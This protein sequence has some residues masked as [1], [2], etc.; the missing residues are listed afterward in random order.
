[1]LS[2]INWEIRDTTVA[3]KVKR[4][5]FQRVKR[6]PCPSPKYATDHNTVFIKKLSHNTKWSFFHRWLLTL[7]H[8][9]LWV[10]MKLSH[11]HIIS[12]KEKNLE[13]RF[14]CDLTDCLPS[15]DHSQKS[16]W[17]SLRE[18]SLRISREDIVFCWENAKFLRNLSIKFSNLLNRLHV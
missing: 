14:I 4:K 2:F 17:I 3:F 5:T 9:F 18:H 10:E 11:K 1:M 12:F 6:F 13:T 15:V 16:P 8:T 7:M